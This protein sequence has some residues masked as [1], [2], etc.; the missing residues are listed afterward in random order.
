MRSPSRN[1]YAGFIALVLALPGAGHAL[2]PTCHTSSDYDITVTETGLQFERKNP[3][4]QRLE[5][6]RGELAIDSRAVVLGADDRKRVAAF[7]SRVRE[8]VPK[9]KTIAQRGVDLMVMAIRE[10]AVSAAPESASQ[11]DI[12][13]RVDARARQLKLKIARST[14][15]KEWHADAL[16]GDLA[17]LL[18]D[19]APLLTG[20]LARQALDRTL[21]GDLAG[22]IALKDRAVALRGSLE[23]RVR[24]KLDLLQPDIGRLCPALRELDRLE[25][26]V[27]QRLPD[28]SRLN[29]IKLDS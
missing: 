2:E 22:V 27:T 20:D 25:N 7:E 5:M 12:N 19:V 10:E 24:A 29:L 14:T 18:S 15:S 17:A 11:P 23:R 28:G 4:G 9:V 26:S 6:R 3:A 13:A 16:Q 8:L 21:K 1:F